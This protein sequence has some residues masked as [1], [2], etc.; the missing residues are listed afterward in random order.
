MKKDNLF[1]PESAPTFWVNQVSRLLTRH[2]E[3]RLRPFDAG[4]AY[5][6]VLFGLDQSENGTLLQKQL[7]ELAYVEQPTMAAL[8][9]RMERDGLIERE[10]HPTDKRASHICLSEKA[11]QRLPSVKEEIVAVAE[12][13]MT[14]FTDEERSAL[15]CLLQR[16]A[17]NLNSST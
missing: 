11:K 14:G 8:L 13:A 2:F 3:Q 7:V 10:A 12:Q 4:M 1:D 5:L 17:K 9:T 15:I 16:V 6:P